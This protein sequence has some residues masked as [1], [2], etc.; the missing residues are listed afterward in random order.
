M[1]S[2]KNSMYLTLYDMRFWT[3]CKFAIKQLVH[4][5]VHW[6]N[7]FEALWSKWPTGEF[8]I[9]WTKRVWINPNTRLHK[10][11]INLTTIF[12]HCSRLHTR[13][14]LILYNQIWR[15]ICYLIIRSHIVTH[16]VLMTSTRACQMWRTYPTGTHMHWC[17]PMYECVNYLCL[18]IY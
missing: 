4:K 5:Q 1:V 13:K 2:D 7:I 3:R 15:P 11:S 12:M 9:E 6:L 8:E 17:A 18:L 16:A 10:P 14:C